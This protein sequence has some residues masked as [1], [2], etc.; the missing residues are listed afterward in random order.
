MPT[1]LKSK[2]D[3]EF[4]IAFASNESAE[5]VD[6]KAMTETIKRAARDFNN[7]LHYGI[8]SLWNGQTPFANNLATTFISAKFVKRNAKDAI[9]F[10]DSNDA[11]INQDEK[12]MGVANTAN[13]STTI[14]ISK[15]MDI[16][17]QQD[18]EI[19]LRD[20]IVGTIAPNS[21]V[22]APNPRGS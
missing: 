2:V 21:L 4:N 8:I 12:L 5:W 18:A 20:G 19:Q 14:D 3:I 13:I 11:I 10:V 7:T 9:S 17:Q 1:N 6:A 15:Y 16:V 22:L